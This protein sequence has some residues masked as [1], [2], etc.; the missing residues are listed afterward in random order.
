MRRCG[1]MRRGW[2]VTCAMQS[3]G[4]SLRLGT[5]ARLACSTLC[6]VDARSSRCRSYC[7]GPI[8]ARIP[9]M[10]ELI[11]ITGDQEQAELTCMLSRASHAMTMEL[12][13][14]LDEVG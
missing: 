8:S 1:C 3:T 2:W 4:A 11:E 9:R 5:E 13:A 10:G 14:A 6:L 7:S 12:A